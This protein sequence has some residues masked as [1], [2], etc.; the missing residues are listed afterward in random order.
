MACGRNVHR[1]TERHLKL[2]TGGR[3]STV[4]VLASAAASGSPTQGAA[5]I[6]VTYPRL[7]AIAAE[8]VGGYYGGKRFECVVAGLSKF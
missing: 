2:V 6:S 3:T 1:Q 8:C 5:K 4:N 7:D